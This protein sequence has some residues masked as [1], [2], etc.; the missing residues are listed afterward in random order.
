MRTLVLLAV[1]SA[2]LALAGIARPG[3]TGCAPAPAFRPGD[4]GAVA[5]WNG[6]AVHVVDV[7]SGSDRALVRDAGRRSAGAP[8]LW[9]PD[10]RWIAFGDLIVS[11]AEGA[12]CRPLG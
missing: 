5:Y 8:L 12:V 10:G 11:A 4:L 2:G 6:S 7:A 9:S 1:A 3:S